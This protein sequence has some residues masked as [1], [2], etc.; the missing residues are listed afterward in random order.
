M[1]IQLHLQ[2]L[3]WDS[4]HPQPPRPKGFILYLKNTYVYISASH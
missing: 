1:Q 2:A 4:P 3:G